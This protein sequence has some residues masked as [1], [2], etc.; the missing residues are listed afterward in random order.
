MN[1]EALAHFANYQVHQFF[2]Q[3]DPLRVAL[4]EI[5][6]PVTLDDAAILDRVSYLLNCEKA[7]GT[8]RDK[9]LPF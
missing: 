7:L 9:G 1:D 4:F 3:S 2:K 5:L 6:Q 8:W